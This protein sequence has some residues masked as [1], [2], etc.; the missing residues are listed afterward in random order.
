MEPIEDVLEV[1]VDVLCRS[2]H[3]GEAWFSGME[4]R[5]AVVFDSK[6]ALSEIAH[7]GEQG[8]SG[9]RRLAQ[10]LSVFADAGEGRFSG[11]SVF[12]DVVEGRFSGTDEGEDDVGSIREGLSPIA[13]AGERRFSGMCEEVEVLLQ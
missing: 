4:S 2:A 8:F 1:G 7:A 11:M 9:M 5:R 3:P 12:A 10:D 6:E 13:D